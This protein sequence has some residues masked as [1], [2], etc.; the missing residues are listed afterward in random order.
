[1]HIVVVTIHKTYCCIFVLQYI[2]AQFFVTPLVNM[3]LLSKVDGDMKPL[4]YHFAK[5]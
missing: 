4:L 2:V 3:Y 1:M 5:W